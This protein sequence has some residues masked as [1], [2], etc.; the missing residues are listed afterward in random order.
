[1]AEKIDY[2]IGRWKRWPAVVHVKATL[3][4]GAAAS[5]NPMNSYIHA[6]GCMQWE[7]LEK[8]VLDYVDSNQIHFREID[9][10]QLKADRFRR[11]N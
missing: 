11:C 9:S 7:D 8:L 6:D 5:L 1:M 2:Q 3:H 4:G 10:L